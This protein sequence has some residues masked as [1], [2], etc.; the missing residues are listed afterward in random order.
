MPDMTKTNDV[1]VT[2]DKRAQQ[3][4]EWFAEYAEHHRAKA[5]AIEALPGSE[6]WQKV[7]RNLERARFAY[8]LQDDIALRLATQPDA[9]SDGV[10]EVIPDDIL[11]HVAKLG[12]VEWGQTPAHDAEGH[13]AHVADIVQMTSEHFCQTEDQHMHGLYLEG[14]ETVLCHTGTSPNAPQTTRALV[15]AWNWLCDQATLRNQTKGSTDGLR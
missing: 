9:Q 10:R 14:T 13:G 6:A 2:L 15:G 1:W 4:G 11:N 12:K 5:E 3:L 7:E 8:A